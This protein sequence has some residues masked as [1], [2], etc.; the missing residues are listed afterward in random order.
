M[1]NLILLFIIIQI[2][3]SYPTTSFWV[4]NNTE[5]EVNF[6]A[7]A[8][9]LPSHSVRTLPFSVPPMD[10][11]LLRRV[12]LKEGANVT[13]IF[14]DISFMAMDSIEIKDPMNPENWQK[15]KDKTG[16]TVFIFKVKSNN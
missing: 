14:R 7:G 2:G 8:I 3:C 10:S 16:K 9:H 4:Q 11:V 1:K 13:N 12:G 15:G 6:T 5:N